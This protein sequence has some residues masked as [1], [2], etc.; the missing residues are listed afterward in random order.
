VTQSKRPCVGGFALLAFEGHKVFFFFC[1]GISRL[2]KRKW[3]GAIR[4]KSLKYLELGLC[5]FAE[6]QYVVN[7]G[8]SFYEGLSS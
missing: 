6:V 7:L 4:A 8:N 3:G 2:G 1:L 5:K